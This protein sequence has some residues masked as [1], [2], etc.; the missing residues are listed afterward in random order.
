M[1]SVIGAFWR[2]DHDR[3][4]KNPLPPLPAR[5]PGESDGDEIL[6]WQV[7]RYDFQAIKSQRKRWE[8]IPLVR[9][10]KGGGRGA[11]LAFWED[12]DLVT[13]G[14]VVKFRSYSASYGVP[15]QLF[16]RVAEVRFY[17][18]HE[19]LEILRSALRFFVPHERLAVLP[20]QD[21][22]KELGTDL[23]PDV[24]DA[25]AR[26]QVYHRKYGAD[27][28]AHGFVAMRLKWEDFKATVPYPYGRQRVKVTVKKTSGEIWVEIDV[29]PVLTTLAHIVFKEA[30]VDRFDLHV[31][32]LIF[33]E[34]VQPYWKSLMQFPLV[35]DGGEALELSVVFQP[36][37]TPIKSLFDQVKPFRY[38]PGSVL[39]PEMSYE[40]FKHCF[41]DP[42]DPRYMDMELLMNTLYPEQKVLQIW[43]M[44]TRELTRSSNTHAV[45]AYPV[46]TSDGDP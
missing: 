35:R 16:M 44:S 4:G 24:A 5:P 15:P 32:Y 13:E 39:D 25:S 37:E 23:L 41:T 20:Q 27:L 31:P 33:N 19:L 30:R 46:E 9:R 1:G 6:L 2:E 45:E 22:V 26:V 38:R 11:A 3:F 28:C 10:M 17:V 42:Y 21:M 7:D 12:L 14:R 36:K 8:A 43:T 40:K 29:W 34:R 18:P